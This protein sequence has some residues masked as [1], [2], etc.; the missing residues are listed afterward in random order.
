LFNLERDGIR[1]YELKPE[2][3]RPLAGR[4]AHLGASYPCASTSGKTFRALF[5]NLLHMREITI[6]LK[7][8]FL[9][10]G[11]ACVQTASRLYRRHEEPSETIVA[12]RRRDYRAR[13]LRRPWKSIPW[14]PASV[15]GTAA[16]ELQRISPLLDARCSVPG[17]TAGARRENW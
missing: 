11:T 16:D 2:E 5:I 14:R 3:L 13:W 10:P 12:P 7:Q 1:P 17:G 9:V 6:K 15:T 4:R 8:L